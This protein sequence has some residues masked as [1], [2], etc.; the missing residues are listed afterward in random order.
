MSLEKPQTATPM[1][2][3][4]ELALLRTRAAAERTLESWIRTCLS[5][6]SFGFGI[7][8]LIEYVQKTLP[9][10][11]IDPIRAGRILGMSFVVLGTLSMWAAVY[12]HWQTLRH[13]KRREFNYEA[14]WP[15]GIV[16]GIGLILIGLFAIVAEL[17]K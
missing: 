11:N 16:V 6:I 13:L 9:G 17:L 8:K 15:L 2:A 5:L 14:R 3:S 10:R 7:E 1:D 4:T 12:Q